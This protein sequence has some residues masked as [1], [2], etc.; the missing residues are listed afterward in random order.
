MVAG[1]TRSAES[2]H[3]S[4]NAGLGTS[5]KEL[6]DATLVVA[7]KRVLLKNPFQLI[8]SGGK[9]GGHELVECAGSVDLRFQS[10][11]VGVTDCLVCNAALGRDVMNRPHPHV[12]K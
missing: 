10:P 3:A 12:S 2:R 6:S 4:S 1:A 11:Q 7:I 9:P 5:R 8:G